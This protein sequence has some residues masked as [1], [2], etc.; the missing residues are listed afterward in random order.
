VAV[1]GSV[2]GGERRAIVLADYTFPWSSAEKLCR[3]LV[4][5]PELAGLGK[6]FHVT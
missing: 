5:E 6:V 3:K 4:V 2:C 1:F